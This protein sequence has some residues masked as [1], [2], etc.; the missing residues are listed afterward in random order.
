M[1]SLQNL[2]LLHRAL[3]FLYRNERP[4][5]TPREIKVASVDIELLH[6]CSVPNVKG[7]RP[8]IA[9][10]VYDQW[11]L[12]KWEGIESDKIPK[13]QLCTCKKC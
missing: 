2:L 10:D 3:L 13:R 12:Q 4:I 1:S 5:R 6:Y 7:L 11:Y 8:W 9:C